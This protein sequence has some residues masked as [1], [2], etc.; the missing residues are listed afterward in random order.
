M[1]V[2]RIANHAIKLDIPEKY[3]FEN[4]DAFRTDDEVNPELVVS[5]HVNEYSHE[6]VIK[7]FQENTNHRLYFTNYMLVLKTISGYRIFY[8]EMQ[9]VLFVDIDINSWLCDIHTTTEK[10][11]YQ[12]S[13][14]GGNCGSCLTACDNTLEP[15]Q[16]ANQ[17]FY[18]IRDIF[19]LYTQTQGAIAVHSS[20]LLYRDRAYLFIAPSGTGK[21]THTDMWEKLYRVTILDGDVVMLSIEDGRAYAYGLPWCGTSQK[22]QNKRVELGGIFVLE[23]ANKNEICELSGYEGVLALAARNFSPS[24]TKEYTDMNFNYAE[25]IISKAYIVKLKCMPNEES[26]QV[27]KKYIDTKYL[28]F[29]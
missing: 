4:F 18:I 28:Q 19:L 16:T 22:Y 5:I 29:C 12:V 1:Y 11:V 23:R 15:T 24:W 17:I 21:T 9:Y 10:N 2:Y 27:V 7:Y 3:I 26:T 20:S 8:P 25:M 6:Y 13:S 14:C